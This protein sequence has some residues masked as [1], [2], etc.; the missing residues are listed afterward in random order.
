MIV[1]EIKRLR[2]GFKSFEPSVISCKYAQERVRQATLTFVLQEFDGKQEWSYLD[3]DGAYYCDGLAMY[4]YRKGLVYEVESGKRLMQGKRLK[5]EA[6]IVGL[7]STPV[8]DIAHLP[9]VSLVA[10]LQVKATE[11]EKI[12]RDDYFGYTFDA[13]TCSMVERDGVLYVTVPIVNAN[14]LILALFCWVSRPK[15]LLLTLDE[16]ILQ[17][18]EIGLQLMARVCGETLNLF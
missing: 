3:Q 12:M 9:G 10:R 1:N 16:E 13:Q 15:T 18:Q 8:V 11:R 17:T 6:Y 2:I 4:G 14:N 5:A 7:R